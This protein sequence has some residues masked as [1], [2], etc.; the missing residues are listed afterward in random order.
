M[1]CTVHNVKRTK[2]SELLSKDQ[3]VDHQCTHFRVYSF[4]LDLGPPS[5][6]FL[7][8]PPSQVLCLME[9]ARV[10]YSASKIYP[11]FVML[12]GDANL[13]SNLHFDTFAKLEQIVS[14]RYP[15][16]TR[17]LYTWYYNFNIF[18]TLVPREYPL[19]TCWVSQYNFKNNYCNGFYT[20]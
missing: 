18:F 2:Q 3:L 6:S 8:T 5:W 10:L 11:I 9:F 1:R 13:H 4:G 15:T 14:T 19:G 7:F 12:D 17:R 20:W 16:G